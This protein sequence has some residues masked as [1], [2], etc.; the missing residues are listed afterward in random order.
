MQMVPYNNLNIIDALNL[1]IFSTDQ[2][3]V[4]NGDP[5][6]IHACKKN[7]CTILKKPMNLRYYQ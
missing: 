5:K 7:L 2:G 4:R 3:E 6:R 1:N